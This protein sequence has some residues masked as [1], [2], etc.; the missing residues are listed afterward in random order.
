M[1]VSPKPP[2]FLILSVVA[3][4]N[5]TG[6][7]FYSQF[8]INIFDH[9][10]WMINVNGALILGILGISAYGAATATLMKFDRYTSLF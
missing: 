6:T 5:E 4:R 7:L 3:T 10:V 2:T 1:T 8:T 9:L